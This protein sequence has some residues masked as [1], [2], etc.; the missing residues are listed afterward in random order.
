M[1]AMRDEP[2]R[3]RGFAALILIV[4]TSMLGSTTAEPA[5]IV[6][7]AWGS[8]SPAHGR[9]DYV[10]REGAT[11]GRL[12][13]WV[14]GQ[15]SGSQAY[16]FNLEFWNPSGDHLA[17]AWRFDPEGCQAESL[18]IFNFRNPDP[19]GQ[20]CG[21]GLSEPRAVYPVVFDNRYDA[22]SRRA[23]VHVEVQYLSPTT[24]ISPTARYLLAEFYFEQYLTSVN[25]EATEQGFCGD[26]EEPV[27]FR[28]TDARYQD[29]DGAW[30]A[31][32]IDAAPV[33]AHGE[34][35]PIPQCDAVP[36]RPT[37]WGAVKATYR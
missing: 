14:E 35:T 2:S 4:G 26:F 18:L 9:P 16:S 11:S 37:T 19:T 12:L 34:G 7:M 29:P 28:V 17:D 32:A 13:L 21:F 31:W 15:E 25:G 23:R 3:A 10:T 20:S 6:K 30:I 1:N 27:C 22:V 33:T 36:A 24:S 5:P 8:C